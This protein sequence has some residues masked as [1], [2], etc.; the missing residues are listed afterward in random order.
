MQRD[1]NGNEKKQKEE[2]S[3]KER[4]GRPGRKERQIISTFT[5]I[6]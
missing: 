5:I 4:K 3:L 2:K 1:G 6:K